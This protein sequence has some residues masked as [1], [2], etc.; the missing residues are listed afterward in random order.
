MWSVGNWL[1]R[2]RNPTVGRQLAGLVI[3]S[4]LQMVR[5]DGLAVCYRELDPAVRV[6]PLRRAAEQAAT[7]GLITGTAARQWIED[8]RASSASGEFLL[9]ITLFTVLATKPRTTD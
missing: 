3:R 8:L 9:S 7:D 4:G 5:I 6:F 1:G 2:N